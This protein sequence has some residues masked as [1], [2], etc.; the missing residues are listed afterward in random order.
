MAVH[1]GFWRFINLLILLIVFVAVWRGFQVYHQDK[2][3]IDEI[4][5]QSVLKT[6]SFEQKPVEITTSSGLTAWLI[7]EHSIP[8]ISIGFMFQR[9]GN[10]YDPKGMFGLSNAAASLMTKGAGEYD[11]AAFQE[12]LEL[13][14]IN[15]SFSS[16][17]ENLSG[18]LTTPTENASEAYKILHAALNAPL[19]SARDLKVVQAQALQALKIQREE[20]EVLLN[21]SFNQKIFGAHPYSRHP[22]GKE[23]DILSLSPQDLK[24]YVQ[25]NLARDNLII[26]IAGDITPQAA[27]A[28]L[29]E[30]F[31]G[32][33]LHSKAT[34]L[35]AP[36][37]NLKPGA[38]YV[39]E[40][41]NQIGSRFAVKGVRRNDADFY[42]LYVANYIFGGAG[43]T[44]RLSLHA[45]EKENLTYGIYT[46]LN[47]DEKTPLIIGQFYAAAENYPLMMT[48][49]SEEWQK[50]AAEGATAKEVEDA[51]NYL[52]AS[53]NLRFNSVSG[54]ADMLVAM[55]KYH[56]GLDFLQKRN[57]YI[58]AVNIKDV[59]AAAAKYF[60]TLPTEV[61]I[62]N[63]NNNQE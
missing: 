14:G 23:E 43:L 46:Y 45:R 47:D 39:K 13:N 26:G 9:A 37:M 41:V 15:L 35:P 48:I 58:R 33:P 40:D 28:A 10:A 44:S 31:D 5:A 7:E 53:Y 34:E 36:D 27:K 62:G 59:N 56:L 3:D 50:F 61:H 52:L 8:I 60:T 29:E 30:I 24:N 17:R 1:K 32:L 21:L 4:V 42:P 18:I 25:E 54:L 51:K 63:L 22:I 38:T 55:Q 49:L 6:K 11:R 19:F 57:D 12:V 20:P 16:G 2:I